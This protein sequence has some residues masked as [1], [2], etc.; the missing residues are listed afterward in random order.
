MKMT[1]LL[2]AIIFVIQLMILLVF[3]LLAYNNKTLPSIRI[4]LLS[5]LMQVGLFVLKLKSLLLR[6]L[7]IASP[8]PFLF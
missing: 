1:I 5:F 6:Y 3:Y 7:Q 2:I 8:P 4:N